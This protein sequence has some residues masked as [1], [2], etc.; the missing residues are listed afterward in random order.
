MRYPDRKIW[1]VWQPHTYS[2]T[3]ALFN[4]F[5]NCFT[6]ADHVI[7]SQVYASREKYD[8]FSAESVVEAM[9]HQDVRYIASLD[10]ITK[11][12]A[13]NLTSGDV[14]FVFSAGDAV[15]V[16]KNV[17]SSLSQKENKK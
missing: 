1:A 7:I 3:K 13:K 17:Y 2:R 6:E 14:L 9:V 12:L 11:F 10:E 8:G 5:I 16:T 4:E 15:Q